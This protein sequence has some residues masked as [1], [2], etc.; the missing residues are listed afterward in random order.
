MEEENPLWLP[1]AHSVPSS[2]E[3]NGGYTATRSQKLGNRK[4]EVLRDKLRRLEGSRDRER[5]VEVC[6]GNDVRE[7]Y[8]KFGQG[9]GEVS[10]DSDEGEWEKVREE[11]RGERWLVVPEDPDEW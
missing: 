1:S 7:L 5:K 10:E 3:T 8:E 11:D 6:T 2:Y 9:S 4:V